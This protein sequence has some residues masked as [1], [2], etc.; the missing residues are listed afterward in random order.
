MGNGYIF[1]NAFP[2]EKAF[3][4]IQ[5]IDFIEQKNDDKVDNIKNWNIYMRKTSHQ[6][7]QKKKANWKAYCQHKWRTKDQFP[8]YAE[9]LEIGKKKTK[10]GGDILQ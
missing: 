3:S 1:K 8:S 10:K 5:S 9:F 7:I 2:D 4:M 6:N